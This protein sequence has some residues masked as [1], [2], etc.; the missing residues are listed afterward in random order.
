MHTSWLFVERVLETIAAVFQ[1]N[2]Y[3]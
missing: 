1:S 3:L 2:R